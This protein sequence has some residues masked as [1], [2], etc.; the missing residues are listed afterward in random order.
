[1]SVLRFNEVSGLW[2]FLFFSIYLS[3]HRMWLLHDMHRNKCFHG[4][5]SFFQI[6]IKIA[7]FFLADEIVPSVFIC[8]ARWMPAAWDRRSS[9]PAAAGC[10]GWRTRGSWLPPGAEGPRGRLG[11]FL[12][13]ASACWSFPHRLGPLAAVGGLSPPSAYRIQTVSFLQIGEFITIDD[14]QL[15]V[16][17]LDYTLIL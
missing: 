5:W 3:P 6:L 8:H 10:W 1:M 2:C 4:L 14:A 16:F 17:R 15:S 13:P 12:R 11:G 7:F 9:C